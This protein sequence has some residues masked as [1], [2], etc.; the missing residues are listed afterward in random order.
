[1]HALLIWEL[2]AFFYRASLWAQLACTAEIITNR[3]RSHRIQ[4]A[5]LASVERG[6]DCGVD[7]AVAL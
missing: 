7:K 4:R 1:M 3:F 5:T 6:V 2:V